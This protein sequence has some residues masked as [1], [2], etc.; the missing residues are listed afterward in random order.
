MEKNAIDSGTFREL[1]SSCWQNK[2]LKN[3]CLTLPTSDRALNAPRCGWNPWLDQLTRIMWNKRSIIESY[4]SNHTLETICYPFEE[5]RLERD[6]STCETMAK[7]LCSIFK[8][9]RGTQNKSALARRKILVAHY[10]DQ[11]NITEN[12]RYN[13]Y[14]TLMETILDSTG[15]ME[16]PQMLPHFMMWIGRDA[17][18]L[19][20]MYEL[21]HRFPLLCVHNVPAINKKRSRNEWMKKDF[22]GDV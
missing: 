4:R 14:K 22:A 7:N 12:K 21:V 11:E 16:T 6:L 13:S 17:D 3:L 1:G 2:S 9:N 8:M 15:D 20:L 5:E 19:P 18:G 10:Y